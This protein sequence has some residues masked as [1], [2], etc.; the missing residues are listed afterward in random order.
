VTIEE[1]IDVM[2]VIE[3]AQRSASEA[4]PVRIDI[5]GR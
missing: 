4:T 1:A 3:A 5:Q 2:V